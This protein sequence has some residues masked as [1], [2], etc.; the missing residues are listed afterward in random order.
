[1]EIKVHGVAIYLDH[2]ITGI[3][4]AN[5]YSVPIQNQVQ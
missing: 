5:E 2:I 1:M 4:Q 3:C